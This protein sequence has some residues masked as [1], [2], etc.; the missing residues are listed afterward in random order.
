MKTDV[1]DEVRARLNDG[2]IT[3]S[4]VGGARQAAGWWNW[5]DAKRALEVL[6]GRGEV[7]CTM[8]RNWKRVYDLP[9]RVIPPELLAQQLTPEDCYRAL[10]QIAAEALGIGTRRDIANYFY[11]LPL[12]LGRTLDRAR[13]LDDALAESGLVQIDVEGWS[14]AAFVDPATLNAGPPGESRTTLLSPF[15]SLVW[16]RA[17][18]Q[19]MFDYRF[20]LEAYKPKAQRIHGYFTMPLLSGGRIAG[21]VD[22]ARDGRTF[23]ARSLSL[24][25]PTALDAM[26]SALREA[27]AW[28][29]CDDVRI[30]RAKP[31]RVLSELRR[32]L[33]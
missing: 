2:P 32:A 19:R 11:L 24:H 9:E 18:T 26:A 5:S 12:Y 14:E 4:D 16:D 28:V 3:A 13:L 29:N 30:E 23:V 7:V 21:H 1:F 6:Y 10:V 15:D 8:R 25:D 31:A 27:A 17:R 33:R 20:S 22:P